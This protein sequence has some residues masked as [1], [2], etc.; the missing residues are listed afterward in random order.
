MKR[1]SKGKW[2]DREGSKKESWKEGEHRSAADEIERHEGDGSYGRYNGL[3]VCRMPTAA[4]KEATVFCSNEILMKARARKSKS[5]TDFG[6][7]GL[8]VVGACVT[9]RRCDVVVVDVATSFLSRGS[10][11][12]LKWGSRVKL[13]IRI[14]N[15]TSDEASISGQV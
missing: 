11:T 8:F 12:Y 1:V 2:D 4:A 5:W 15:A 14:L 9:K 3:H 6:S 7:W 10:H 13:F